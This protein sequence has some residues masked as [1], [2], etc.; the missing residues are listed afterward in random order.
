[1]DQDAVGWRWRG[2][3]LV[4]IGAGIDKGPVDWGWHG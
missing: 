1:M 2:S 4:L 3:E